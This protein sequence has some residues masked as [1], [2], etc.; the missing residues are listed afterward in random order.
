[1]RR[2]VSQRATRAFETL[3]PLLGRFPKEIIRNVIK[4]YCDTK[5]FIAVVFTMVQIGKQSKYLTI[6]D[7]I[8]LHPQN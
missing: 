1:M 6:V 7:Q 4:Y 3:T 5:M 8:Y 2:A